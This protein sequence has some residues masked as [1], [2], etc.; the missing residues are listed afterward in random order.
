MITKDQVLEAQ[1]KWG[2]GVVKIGSLKHSRSECEAFASS[3]LDE[4]YAFGLGSVIFKPTKC[5]FEQFRPSKSQALSYFI[6][7]DD[8]ACDEDKGFAIQPWTKVRFEN[9]GIILEEKRAIAMGNYFF[10]D[11]DGNEAKVEY[12]F[13]YK[14]VGDELKIDLHHSSFPYKH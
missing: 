7:G 2:S 1:E 3:F 8:R 13:G 9:A 14:L 4:R 11:L 12:T 10:T 6:A 5:E